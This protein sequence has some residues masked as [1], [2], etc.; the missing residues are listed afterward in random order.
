MILVCELQN[1]TKEHLVEF[2]GNEEMLRLKLCDQPTKFANN[3]L[4]VF[5]GSC[6]FELFTSEAYTVNSI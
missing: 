6:L 3:K 2:E 4:F 1:K 5:Y